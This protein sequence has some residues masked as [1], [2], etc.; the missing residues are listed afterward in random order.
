MNSWMGNFIIESDV[1]I[2]MHVAYCNI[3]SNEEYLDKWIEFTK[4]HIL[5]PVINSKV[6]LDILNNLVKPITVGELSSYE[7][8]HIII[9][10]RI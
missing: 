10:T 8:N 2:K 1:I 6:F 9:V 4:I 7:V 3:N 5:N